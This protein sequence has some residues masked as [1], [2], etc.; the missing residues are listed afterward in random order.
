MSFST[1]PRVP[2]GDNEVAGRRVLLLLAASLVVLG[3]CGLL[4]VTVIHRPSGG[5]SADKPTTNNAVAASSSIGP[6]PGDDLGGYVAGRST[7]LS[8]ATGDRSA[9]VSLPAYVNETQ[10]R[11]A[12]G[13]AKVVGLL[14]AVPGGL[15]SVVTGSM[16]MWVNGQ[17]ADKRNDRDEMQ[18]LLPTVDDP[19]FKTFYQ[20]EIVRLD[21]LLDAVKPDGPLV[22]GV[23][24]QAPAKSLQ[25]LAASGQVRL[26]D[27]GTT[28]T[29]PPGTP[30]RGVRP[31]ETVKAN[32]PPTR[33][34]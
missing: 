34:S 31:E 29:L 3:L 33:P 1:D 18:S 13:Q 11:A 28:A 32:G 23:V 7:A 6:E 12:V 17:V 20:D 4:A 2:A 25:A 16:A 24:V 30:I 14:A 9:V 26:V 21:K 19:Q 27:V 22:F 10:A 15:P 8:A 5:K